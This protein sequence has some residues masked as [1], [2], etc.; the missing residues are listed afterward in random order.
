[1]GDSAGG[2]LAAAA[3]LKLRDLQIPQPAALAVL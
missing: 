2:K 3:V 1:M